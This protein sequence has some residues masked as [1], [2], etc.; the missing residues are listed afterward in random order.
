[1]KRRGKQKEHVSQYDGCVY[2]Y[3]I[4]LH[5]FTLPYGKLDPVSLVHSRLIGMK[6][7]NLGVSNLS[8]LYSH[9]K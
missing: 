5:Y 8:T 1:M 2:L 3:S 4:T 7:M 9:G 6:R